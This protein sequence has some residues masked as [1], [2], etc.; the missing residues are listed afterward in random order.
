MNKNNMRISLAAIVAALG[1]LACSHSAD[2]YFIVTGTIRNAT[3]GM[4]Y[5]EETPVGGM[6]RI[7]VDSAK[8]GKDSSFRFQTKAPEESMFNIKVGKDLYPVASLINDKDKVKV[9]IDLADSENMYNVEGSPASSAMKS[10]IYSNGLRLRDIYEHSLELDSLARA[11]VPD[12]VL[13]PLVQ[14]FGQKTSSLKQDVLSQI[15]SSSSPGLTMFY[16]NYYQTLANTAQVLHLEPLTNEEIGNIIDS[17][18][19]RFPDHKGIASVKQAF[20]GDQG[21]GTLVG[22]PAPDFTLPD[23]QG[24][25]VSLHS[26]RGKYVLVDFWASWC[27]PCRAEN[28]N[29]VRAYKS[30]KDKNFAILGVSLDRPGQKDNWLKAIH[31]DGLLWTQVSDLQFWNSKVVPLY[32]LEGIPYNVLI[33]PQGTII[34]EN[35]RGPELELKLSQVLN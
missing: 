21:G 8:I 1:L 3:A 5:L 16:L 23:V 30:Y 19:A 6:Q 32:N 18:A 7:V 24:N 10:F 9:N 11:R 20:E 25:D 29:I 27:M 28:P 22:K 35:L 4:L 14:E 15:G 13:E 12:S 26:F 31:D 34:A 33:D 17:A 2:Q